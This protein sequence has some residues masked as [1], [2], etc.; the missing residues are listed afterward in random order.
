M[1]CLLLFVAA[2]DGA[3][4]VS[5]PSTGSGT[6]T[7]TTTTSVVEATTTVSSTI[8]STQPDE[9]AEVEVEVA[10]GTSSLAGQKVKVDLGQAVT[11]RISS[12]VTD[13]LHLH[14]YDLTVDVE[15]GGSAELVFVAEIPGIFEVELEESGLLLFE[16]EVGP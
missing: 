3:S 14:G 9:S 2:C 12:D 7:T 16:L 4:S 11:I 8:S 6:T 5:I 10:G 13:E 1:A 15:A